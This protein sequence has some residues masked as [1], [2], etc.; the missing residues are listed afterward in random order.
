VENEAHDFVIDDEGD[1][2][3]VD[4]DQDIQQRYFCLDEHLG[5]ATQMDGG[6][7]VQI[8]GAYSKK[9]VYA[10]MSFMSTTRLH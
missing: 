9:L 5:V 6:L 3:M 8:Y 7:T 4:P 1:I 2:V 10:M